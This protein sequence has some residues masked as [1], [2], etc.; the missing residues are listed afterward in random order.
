VERLKEALKAH[1]PLEDQIKE[2]EVVGTCLCVVVYLCNI[3]SISW[4]G[5]GNKAGIGGMGWDWNRGSP[6]ILCMC[7]AHSYSNY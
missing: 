2:P 4:V 1:A 3:L 7:N 6:G 5:P